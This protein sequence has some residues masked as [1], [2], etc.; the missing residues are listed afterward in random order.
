MSGPRAFKTSGLF[1]SGPAVPGTLFPELLSR[2]LR[3]TPVGRW[4]VPLPQAKT[5]FTHTIALF[6]IYVF[7]SFYL[8]TGNAAASDMPFQS[9][10]CG[11][12]MY[13]TC[14]FFS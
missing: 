5:G 14:D 13:L 9:I 12:S 6:C 2:L 3:A 11:R 4:T 1:C 7:P 8:E 10:V